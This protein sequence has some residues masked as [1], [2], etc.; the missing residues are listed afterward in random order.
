MILNLVCGALLTIGVIIFFGAVIGVLR[1]PDFYSR[2]HAAGISDTMS[3]N[4]LL[5]AFAVYQLHDLS[6]PNL[7][8]VGKIFFII[9]FISL[10]GPTSTHA[11]MHAGYQRRNITSSRPRKKR[12]RALTEE[13]A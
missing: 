6:W 4:C 3:T 10:T 9:A 11:L 1:F 12:K 13:E 8:V 2:M 7:L 5:I